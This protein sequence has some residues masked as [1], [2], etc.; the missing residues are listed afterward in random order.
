[1][2]LLKPNYFDRNTWWRFEQSRLVVVVV[3]IYPVY[4]GDIK[5]GYE[6]GLLP[7]GKNKT[8]EE[9]MNDMVSEM[10]YLL[11]DGIKPYIKESMQIYAQQEVKK[12]L[13]IAANIARVISGYQSVEI[14]KSTYMVN[15][16]RFYQVSKESITNIEI[17]LS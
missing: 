6:I 10:P 4:V 16:D 17:N 9:I 8:A 7:L 12:H 5:S 13:E 15:G 2:P 3:D 11:N 14:P 1:M